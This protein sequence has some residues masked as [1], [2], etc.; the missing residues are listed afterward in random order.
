MQTARLTGLTLNLSGSEWL[1]RITSPTPTRYQMQGDAGDPPIYVYCAQDTFEYALISG[2][3]WRISAKPPVGATLHLVLTLDGPQPRTGVMS[4]IRPE[5]VTGLPNVEGMP[6]RCCPYIHFFA[7]TK[8]Y[9]TWHRQLPPVI[10]PRLQFLLLHDAWVS[11]QSALA[12]CS[13]RHA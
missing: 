2:R 7:S 6:S 10:Q 5:L 8:T 1:A 11:A 9:E 12:A 13:R 3:T 4:T